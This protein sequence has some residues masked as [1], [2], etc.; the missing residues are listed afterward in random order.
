MAS[1][2][3]SGKQIEIFGENGDKL[4]KWYRYIGY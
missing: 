1:G 4:I 3:K 2:S